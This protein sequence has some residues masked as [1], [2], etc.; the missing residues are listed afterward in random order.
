MP[1][2]NLNAIH[3]VAAEKTATNAA[4]TALETQLLGKMRNLSPE[5]RQY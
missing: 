1:F 3:Y 2:D 4:L 5:I